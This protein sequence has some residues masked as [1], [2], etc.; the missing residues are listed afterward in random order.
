MV[1]DFGPLL[2]EVLIAVGLKTER[3]IEGIGWIAQFDLEQFASGSFVGAGH[4]F[5]E[6]FGR[7]VAVGMN[8]LKC[9]LPNVTVAGLGIGF[10]IP[11]GRFD[12][13][14]VADSFL[15]KPAIIANLKSEF[16]AG[17]F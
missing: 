13:L 16:E 5:V 7:S 17:S 14:Q 6:Q 3:D 8:G 4:A 15:I 11:F 9:R 1:R 12:R 10:V 2:D